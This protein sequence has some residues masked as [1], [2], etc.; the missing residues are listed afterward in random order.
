MTTYE[1]KHKRQLEVEALHD[2]SE[3]P[4]PLHAP[5][6]ETD[7]VFTAS[8]AAK[9]V[10]G[11]KAK[12]DNLVIALAALTARV[13][14]LEPP[15]ATGFGDARANGPLTRDGLWNGYPA[16]VTPSGARYYVA[17]MNHYRC[18]LNGDTTGCDYVNPATDVVTGVYTVSLGTPPAGTV[19]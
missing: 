19:S 15:T 16:Y 9:F 11:D 4:L 17:D 3:T 1:K 18:S 5:A 13:A 12:L 14:A 7:P 8:E 6:S 2:A 10:S